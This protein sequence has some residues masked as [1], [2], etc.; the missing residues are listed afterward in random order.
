MQGREL[1]NDHSFYI[2]QA[3]ARELYV[4]QTPRTVKARKLRAFGLG[5]GKLKPSPIQRMPVSAH[6]MLTNPHS[7]PHTQ[8]PPHRPMVL[9]P[10]QSDCR[11]HLRPLFSFGSPTLEKYVSYTFSMT[12]AF[13]SFGS[14]CGCSICLEDPASRGA[15]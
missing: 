1:D 9:A 12:E 14:A 3:A 4:A 5:I 7:Y 2:C 15:Q 13:M 6:E 10:R 11:G 8:P